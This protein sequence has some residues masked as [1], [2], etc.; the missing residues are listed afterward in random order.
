LQKYETIKKSCPICEIEFEVKK[1][2]KKEKTT[3]SYSCSSKYFQHGLNN[4]NF[5]KEKYK[6]KKE[7]ISKSIID[8]K[9]KNNEISY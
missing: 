9:N 3:C 7:K 4:P 6:E 8:L 1:G 2:S 5:D